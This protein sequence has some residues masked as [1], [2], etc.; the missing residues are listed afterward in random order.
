METVTVSEKYQI[1]IPKDIR[2]EF[3][4]KPGRKLVFI[5]RSGHIHLVPVGP[6]S[7]ARGIAK[8]ATWEG[9]REKRGRA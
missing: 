3:R 7:A 6:I 1:V 8:G 2:E 5:R 9:I 4:I